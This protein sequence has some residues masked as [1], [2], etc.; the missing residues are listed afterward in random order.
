MVGCQS[1]L[2]S[3]VPF[4]FPSLSE[5]RSGFK[6]PFKTPSLKDF[7][8]FSNNYTKHL[9]L[10]DRRSEKAYRKSFLKFL[11]IE[12]ELLYTL[13]E[14]N[15]FQANALMQSSIASFGKVERDRHRYGLEKQKYHHKIEELKTALSL[16]HDLIPELD[17]VKKNTTEQKHRANTERYGSQLYENYMQSRHRQF[18]R[19]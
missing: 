5:V 15:E 3:Q 17:H 19:Q 9:S 18:A 16:T 12:D 2:I 6:N 10:L 8:K 1:Q 4:K 7:E 11:E 14:S 13:C